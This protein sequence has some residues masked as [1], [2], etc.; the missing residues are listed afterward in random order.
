M[1]RKEVRD[2]PEVGKETF[3][4]EVFQ[5]LF[6]RYGA[7]HWW[8]AD[9]PFEVCVGAI[10]TQNTNWGNV[11]KAI[12]NLK[13]AGLLSAEGLYEIDQERLAELI[14]PSGFF[15]VKSGRLKDFVG[16][17]IQSYGSIDAMFTG[18]WRPLRE[19]L[20][21]VR[22]IGRET[23]DSILLY[24]GDKPSFVVDAY[25]KR[26]FSRL[27][28]IRESADYEEI[29][30]LFMNSLPHDRALFNEYHALI[31]EHCKRHCRKKPLCEGC[32]LKGLCL[33]RLSLG[34]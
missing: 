17:M 7:L 2:L 25:T 10:L 21:A 29:R 14:R 28:L 3:L 16:W 19:E 24:A 6:K 9:T 18:E 15:N 8:P 23:C 20:L 4:M 11:E 27:G 32:P 26:L 5:A 1:G 34:E 30:A 33:N 31:V 13:R 12:L 22:G